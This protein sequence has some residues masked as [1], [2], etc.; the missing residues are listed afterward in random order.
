[1]YRTAQVLFAERLAGV[2]NTGFSKAELEGR[3][4]TELQRG[5]LLAAAFQLFRRNRGRASYGGTD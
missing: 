1:M 5:D 4:L 3:P 2:L